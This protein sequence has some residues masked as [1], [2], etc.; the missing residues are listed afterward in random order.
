MKERVRQ[1]LKQAIIEDKDTN[2]KISNDKINT[3]KDKIAA[4]GKTANKKPNNVA[5]PLPPLK[6]VKTGNKWPITADKPKTKLSSRNKSGLKFIITSWLERNLVKFTDSQPF[7]I[8]KKSTGIPAFFPKTLKVL[9]AP[10][11]P[12]PNSLISIL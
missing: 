9:V 6:P 11:L 7:K 12:D 4:K 10:A 1:K 5:I 2:L 3:V 8:S